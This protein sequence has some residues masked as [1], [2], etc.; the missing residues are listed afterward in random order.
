MK[1]KYFIQHETTIGFSLFGFNVFLR[2]CADVL[3][4]A[5]RVMLPCTVTH[6]EAAARRPPDAVR[7]DYTAVNQV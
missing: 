1:G 3:I 4:T 2:C 7:M 6:A 5:N